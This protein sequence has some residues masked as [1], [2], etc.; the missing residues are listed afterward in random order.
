MQEPILRARDDLRQPCA[1][2]GPLSP[3]YY[4]QAAAGIVA[5]IRNAF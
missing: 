4:W 3:S 1:R 5:T 2:V